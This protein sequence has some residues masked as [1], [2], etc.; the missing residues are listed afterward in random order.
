MSA[1]G[2]VHRGLLYDTPQEFAAAVAPVVGDALGDGQVVF[3]TVDD[4]AA[5]ALRAAVGPGAERIR[6][7]PTS[8]P[9]RPT[10]AAF[11]GRLRAW[12]GSDRRTLVVGHYSAITD[13]PGDCA[14]IENGINLLLQDRPLTV[15][16]ACSRS[17]DAAHLH[18]ARRSHPAWIDREAEDP[19]ADFVAAGD[20]SPADPDLWGR[21]V[22]RTTFRGLA[23]LGRVRRQVIEVVAESGMGGARADAAVLAV[24]EAAAL[25]CRAGH[26]SGAPVEPDERERTLEIRL[27][28]TSLF[29]EVHAPGPAAAGRSAEAHSLF[30]RT[31]CDGDE[32]RHLTWFCRRAAVLDHGDAHTVRVLVSRFGTPPHRSLQSGERPV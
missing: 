30:G 17:R 22:L 26:D 32:L 1:N 3:A 8:P 10:P 18:T 14:E 13:D 7:Q 16:C 2:L 5:A 28:D 24:H 19:N 12:S 20:R 25:T 21:P 23:D 11:L 4:E 9:T 15:L 31:V 6:F 29:S 27:S